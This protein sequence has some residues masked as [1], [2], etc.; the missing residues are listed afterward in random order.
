MKSRWLMFRAAAYVW[1]AFLLA[2][3]AGAAIGQEASERL[4]RLD[5]ALIAEN[6]RTERVGTRPNLV[7]ASEERV[8]YGVRPPATLWHWTTFNS[9]ER[10]AKGME[11]G[12][13]LPLKVIKPDFLI[14]RTFRQ[15]SDLPGLFAWVNPA[16]G[17][18]CFG[19]EIYG[20]G[21]AV[22]R[23]RIHPKARAVRVV[24]I[25]KDAEPLQIDLS[26]TDLIF[27]QL[28]GSDGKVL[29]QEWII[30]NP[31]VVTSYTGTPET[32]GPDLEREIGH[33]RNPK[34]RHPASQKH[35]LL[36]NN[37]LTQSR[38][39]IARVLETYLKEGFNKVPEVFRPVR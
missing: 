27:H 7:P 20:W 19:T 39:Y 31:A 33:L 1:F 24:S 25:E 6:R 3:T 17:L 13:T 32:I 5:A 22:L 29:I 35:C 16:A 28:Q 9:L 14:V 26:R 34:Y 10:W 30:L 4:G 11:P 2:L 21:Q 18:G 36:P 12:D 37:L 38:G 15:L 8:R 23:L